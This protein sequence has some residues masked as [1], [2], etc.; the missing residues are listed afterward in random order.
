LD[1]EWSHFIFDS[2]LIFLLYFGALS[3]RNVYRRAG[4]RLTGF[5]RFL[6]ASALLIQGWHA[7]EHTYRIT[8]H[9]QWGC[10]PCAGIMDQLFGFR[11]IFLHFWFNVLALTLPLMVFAWYGMRGDLRR[12]LRG[13]QAE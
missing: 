9:V 10:D 3:L 5:G 1:V 8:R 13:N 2:V 4:L 11:P 7:V 12:L 6:L